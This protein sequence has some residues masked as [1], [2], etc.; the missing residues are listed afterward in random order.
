MNRVVDSVKL[1]KNTSKHGREYAKMSKSVSSLTF[2]SE[3]T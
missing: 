1:E 2:S 3:K